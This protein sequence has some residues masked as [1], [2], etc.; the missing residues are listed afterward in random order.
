MA[1]I[2]LETQP[3][4]IGVLHAL[5]VGAATLGFSPDFRLLRRV[6][7]PGAWPFKTASSETRRGV[8][9][10]TETPSLDLDTDEVRGARPTKQ[11]AHGLD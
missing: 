6:P 5:A 9:I 1:T 3:S 11:R 7:A 10:D 2:K 8:F 4:R